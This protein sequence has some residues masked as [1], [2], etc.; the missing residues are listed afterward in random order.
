MLPAGLRRKCAKRLAFAPHLLRA[1]PWRNAS[2]GSLGALGHPPLQPNA[3]LR[4][5]SCCKRS[6]ADALFPR[7]SGF[8]DHV[9]PKRHFTRNTLRKPIGTARIQGEAGT[10]QARFGFSFVQ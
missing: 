2:A 8:F 7:N 4:S 5:C 3:S 6:A 9:A 10:Q 1:I